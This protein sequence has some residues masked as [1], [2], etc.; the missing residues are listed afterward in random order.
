MNETD[1]VDVNMYFIG[2][3]LPDTGYSKT[4]SKPD[5][6]RINLWGTGPLHLG[7]MCLP[8]AGYCQDN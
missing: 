4:L 5:Y 6:S 2:T 8:R 7:R 1:I 3:Y